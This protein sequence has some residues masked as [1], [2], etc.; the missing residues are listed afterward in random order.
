MAEVFHNSAIPVIAD[1]SC[2]AESD[3]DRCVGRFHGINIKLMKCGGMTPARRMIA[4]ARQLGLGAM[5]GCMTEST[6][7]VSAVAQFLPLLDYVDIDG[8]LLL[9]HDVASGVTFDCGRVI[10]P[11]TNGCGACLLKD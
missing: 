9:A 10:L 2:R 1:E 3:V 7:G 6:V 5:M 4:R 8:P 11:E